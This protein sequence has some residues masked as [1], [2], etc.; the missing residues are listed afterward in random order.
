MT[1]DEIVAAAGAEGLGVVGAFHP[2]PDDDA[3]DD[4][5]T[6]ILLGPAGPGLWT[7]FSASAE[8][9][10][11]APNPMDRWSKRVIDGLAQRMGA[12]ALYPFGG[13][14]WL[15]FQR[16]AQ[17]AEGAVP[18]PVGMLAS[19][20]RGLWVSYRGALA[21]KG[22]IPLPTGDTSDPCAPCS[23]PCTTACPVDAFSA[24]VYDVDRCAAHMRSDAGSACRRGCLVRRA[25]PAGHRLNLP[26]SQRA[27]HMAAF[28]AARP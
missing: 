13:P 18:S 5:G 8:A 12:K 28:L 14:P 16:W 1:L 3:G 11:G 21:F 15:P 24:G 10:D 4:V 17:K 27:F 7:A 20:R 19:A 25:C 2:E 26:E 9:T 22:Q 23:A 6:L